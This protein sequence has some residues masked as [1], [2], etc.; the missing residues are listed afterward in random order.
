MITQAPH[1]P[2]PASRRA[3][4]RAFEAIAI[5]L[6]PSVGHK[7]IQWLLDSG[8]VCIAGQQVLGH[9][10]FG[11][12]SVPVYDVPLHLHHQWCAWCSANVRDAA[13]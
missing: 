8:L 3:A 6:P 11:V 13:A 10:R 2:V 7:T 12:I 4:R 9:D 1:H 5:G